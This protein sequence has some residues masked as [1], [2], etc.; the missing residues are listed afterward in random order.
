MSDQEIKPLSLKKQKLEIKKSLESGQVRQS[1]SHGRSRSVTVEVRKKRH[2]DKNRKND[3][4]IVS[5]D[6]LTQNERALRRAALKAAED[7][8]RTEQ[9][10]T[11]IKK[12]QTLIIKN[13][14]IEKDNENIIDKQSHLKNKEKIKN[15]S[16][17]KEKK[18]SNQC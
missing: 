7:Y 1:F 8:K 6:H 16:I 13:N 14:N 17:K 5:N 12:P 9:Q 15:P 4:N 3:S 10:D 2:F 18:K 11:L